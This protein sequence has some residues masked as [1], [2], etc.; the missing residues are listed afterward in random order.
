V[1]FLSSSPRARPGRQSPRG[2][3]LTPATRFLPTRVAVSSI[4]TPAATLGSAARGLAVCISGNPSCSP[5]VLARRPL[6]FPAGA[7]LPPPH[8][9]SAIPSHTA[10]AL[11][12]ACPSAPL[13]SPR[14]A[15]DDRIIASSVRPLNVGWLDALT[16]LCSTRPKTAAAVLER[17]R[18]VIIWSLSMKW[19]GLR[20][21]AGHRCCFYAIAVRSWCPSEPGHG[22]IVLGIS[23]A[24]AT[25][26]LRQLKTGSLRFT[27]SSAML[28]RP[29]AWA[30][31][32]RPRPPRLHAPLKNRERAFFLTVISLRTLR[33]ILIYYLGEED[34]L[35]NAAANFIS[36]RPQP[37][38]VLLLWTSAPADRAAV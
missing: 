37:S 19:R 21:S 31:C 13:Q 7:A 1:C 3:P 17:P 14:T 6:A 25:H 33:F 18:R 12:M 9:V 5:H 2:S 10:S 32:S 30:L 38:P 24:Q 26:P 4:S 35:E 28:F 27:S 11:G 15:R 23:P 29:P 34:W 36:A 16:K 8:P 22:R 20:L